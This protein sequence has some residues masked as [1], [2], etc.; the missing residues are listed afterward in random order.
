M[1]FRI[2]FTLRTAIILVAVVAILFGLGHWLASEEVATFHCGEGRMIVITAD[3]EWE[4]M[5]PLRYR[6]MV[7]GTTRT[8]GR[9][10]SVVSNANPQESLTFSLITAD[11]GRLAGVVDERYGRRA[12]VVIHDFSTNE[13][14]P[15]FAWND[16]A[17]IAR[18]SQAFQRLQ[19]ENPDVSRG[20]SD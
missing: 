19:A 6:V 1:S 9:A 7:D 3:N 13:S 12:V 5:Q 8:S 16:P 10:F 18:L 20:V 17:N 4:L 11:D 14:W 2:Q 15:S